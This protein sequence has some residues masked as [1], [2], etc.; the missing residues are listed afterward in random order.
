MAR[1]LR[2]TGDTNAKAMYDNASHM[3]S[4]IDGIP[5]SDGLPWIKYHFRYTGLITPNTALWKL[6][7]YVVYARNPLHVAEYIASCTDFKR[8]WDYVPYEE[9]T[10]DT[11]RR[12]C[13]FMSAR[14]PF[15]KAVS[16]LP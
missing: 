9:Y 4:T 6:K 11:C 5:H 15:K 1:A 7:T 8:S 2:E 10:S 13:D 12:F 14:F 3:H 16:T